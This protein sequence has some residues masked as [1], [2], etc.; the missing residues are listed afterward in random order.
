[1]RNA[2]AKLIETKCG[3]CVNF[4]H[5]ISLIVFCCW[6]YCCIS[7]SSKGYFSLFLKD[8]FSCTF[9]FQ[10]YVWVMPIMF[11]QIHF[12][13]VLCFLVIISYTGYGGV[14]SA[15]LNNLKMGPPSKF[16]K[17]LTWPS[18]KVCFFYHKLNN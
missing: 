13:A 14:V 8:I 18:F 16:I 5:Y 15:I 3:L 12:A 9:L 6:V 17:N 11:L 7:H 2:N 4:D 1:M 10:C